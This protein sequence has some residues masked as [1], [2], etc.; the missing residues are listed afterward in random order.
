MSY[1]ALS[2]YLHSTADAAQDYFKANLGLTRLQT[3]A[4][5]DKRI[6]YCP[7]FHGQDSEHYVISVDVSDTIYHSTRWHFVTECQQLSLPVKQYVVLPSGQSYSDFKNDLALAKKAGI[8]VLEI[9]PDGGE[10]TPFA[11]PLPL[12]LTGLRHFDP[13]DF[14]TKYRTPVRNAIQT[15]RGGDPN[16]GCA[17]VYDEIEQ[18]TRLI[19]L[20]THKLGM[21]NQPLSDPAT[22]TDPRTPWVRVVKKLDSGLDRKGDKRA[23]GMTSA[24][25]AQVHGITRH[26]NQSGHKPTGKRALVRRDARLRT[27]MEDALDLLQDLIEASKPIR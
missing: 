2:D 26:R 20:K 1:R 17:N 13:S 6:E 12:S 23:G 5:A 22:L 19:A 9:K 16:K 24:L 11:D 8:G 14:P 18:L 21:W 25:L 4:A 15:F 3:E 27:R 10:V 7:T